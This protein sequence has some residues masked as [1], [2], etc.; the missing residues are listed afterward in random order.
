[1]DS[2]SDTTT[3]APATSPTTN[4]KVI[5]CE[6]TSSGPYK[7]AVS[8]RFLEK[9]LVSIIRDKWTGGNFKTPGVFSSWENTYETS[10]Y[11]RFHMKPGDLIDITNKF[12]M[13]NASNSG[14]KPIKIGDFVGEEGSSSDIYHITVDESCKYDVI[15]EDFVD[16]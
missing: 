16:H 13:C 10:D 2:S 8:Y 7:R 15:Y 6:V 4:H 14:T 1:M 12:A 9:Q 11:G 5:R 3:H